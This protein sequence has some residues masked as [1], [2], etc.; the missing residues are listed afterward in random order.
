MSPVD[1]LHTALQV[2]NEYSITIKKHITLEFDRVL[3]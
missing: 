3:G 1:E 2:L